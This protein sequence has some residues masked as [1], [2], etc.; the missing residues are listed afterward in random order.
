MI[1]VLPLSPPSLPFPLTSILI[2]HRD[3]VTGES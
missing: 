2:K 1:A 3:I